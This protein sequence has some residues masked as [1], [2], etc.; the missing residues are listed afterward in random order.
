[1]KNLT[2]YRFK[3][4]LLL[5]LVTGFFYVGKVD[6]Q[7]INFS[8]WTGSDEITIT[9]VQAMPKLDFNLKQSIITKNSGPVLIN[10]TDLQAVG[11]QIEAPEGFD[12][13]VEVDA[14]QVLRLDG[15]G[16]NLDETVP[17]QIGIAYSNQLSID[18]ASAKGSAVQLPAGFFNVTFPVDRRT[19]G[20]PAPPPTPI[21]GDYVRPKATAWFF[22]YGTLGPVGPVIA[23]NYTENITINVYFTSNE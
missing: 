8:T 15:T 2:T 5:L 3:I 9:S 17:F 23:G 22:I 14:P 13:T 21:S 1:M 12:L 20:A 18:E 10:L 19:A 6:A 11:F 16:S 4:D 7:S